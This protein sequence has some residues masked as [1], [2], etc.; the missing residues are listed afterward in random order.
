LK[1]LGNACSPP[2]GYVAG[3]VVAWALRLTA[4]VVKQ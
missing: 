3:K 1:A 4:R 2:Q